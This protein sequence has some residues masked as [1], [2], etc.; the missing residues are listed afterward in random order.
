M[1][2]RFILIASVFAY[3]RS[4]A[5]IRPSEIDSL[6]SLM[7]KRQTIDLIKYGKAR[8]ELKYRTIFLNCIITQITSNNVVYKKGGALHDQAIDKIKVI[9][10]DE[11][12]IILKFD[13]F[14]RGTILFKFD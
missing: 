9:E 13:E 3:G 11:Y 1:I 10:F 7:Q 4:L 8:I 2:I 12:P 5:Q 14:D 6:N